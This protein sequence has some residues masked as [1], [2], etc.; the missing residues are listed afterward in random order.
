[1][2]GRSGCGVC[3]IESLA[4]L[5]L[6][7]GPM[8]KPARPVIA[9]AAAI[10]RAAAELPAHQRLMRATGCAHAAAWCGRDGEVQAVFEDV[11]RHN[12]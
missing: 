5:D 3:G 1:L 11:G 8:A 9:E 12:A 2:E 10:A 6:A 7:P 4:L